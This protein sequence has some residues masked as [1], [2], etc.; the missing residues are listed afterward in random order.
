MNIF[1]L[2]SE[3]DKGKT[4]DA[5]KK[6]IS[7]D[8]KIVSQQE[9]SHKRSRE[10]ATTYKSPESIRAQYKMDKAAYD[11][12]E[13]IMKSNGKTDGDSSEGS[14][15][16]NST[17]MG[18]ADYK[19]PDITKT[20]YPGT[21]NAYKSGIKGKL[22]KTDEYDSIILKHAEKSGIDPMLCKIVIM[23]ESGGETGVVSYDGAGSLGLTQVTPGN[24]GVD[25]DASKLQDP[26][27]NIEMFNLAVE[28][29]AQTAIRLRGSATVQNT[30]HYWNGDGPLATAYDQSFAEIY[31][32]FGLDPN[33]NYKNMKGVKAGS[34]GS[35]GAKGV[36]GLDHLK[37]LIGQS[38]G[39]G[40][41]YSL[42]AEYAGFL[43]GPGL[44]AG[45]QYSKTDTTGPGVA[46]ADIGSDYNWAK[47]GWKVI[48]NPSSKDL[49][50]GAIANIRRGGNWANYQVDGTYGHTGVISEVSDTNFKIY[51]QNSEKGQIVAE[52]TRPMG[53][54]SSLSSIIIPPK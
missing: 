1:S 53:S 14:G 54:A 44:S 10:Y 45:T 42:T 18:S 30:A 17:L 12:A 8:N 37:S 41:C 47:Y 22:K 34:G 2:L 46:A 36:K 20:V 51:E 40:Q 9:D 3:L 50:P 24:V 6:I 31:A 32:G 35:K 7:N 13:A 39:S 19:G 25:V 38:V 11:A 33:N 52:F 21:N 43:G 48:N 26:D 4:T 16:S 49:V 23:M 27:Y 5:A 15:S 28:L 29:K